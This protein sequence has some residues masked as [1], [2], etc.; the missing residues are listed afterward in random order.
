MNIQ[1][2]KILL[3]VSLGISG[4]IIQNLEFEFNHLIALFFFGLQV[5]IFLHYLYRR[6]TNKKNLILI[7]DDISFCPSNE[8]SQNNTSVEGKQ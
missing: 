5:F 4:L 7:F 3:V 1:N 8:E 6:E 2:F